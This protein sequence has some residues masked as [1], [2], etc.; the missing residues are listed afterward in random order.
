MSCGVGHRC[1]SDP[2]LLWLWCRL[3]AVAPIQPLAWELPHGTGAALK[4]KNQM[5]TLDSFLSLP[6]LS[7]P[8]SFP[9]CSLPFLFLS[10]LNPIPVL[11]FPFPSSY[12]VM[13]RCAEAPPLERE[14]EK[15]GEVLWRQA[16]SGGAPVPKD[17]G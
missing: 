12:R 2:E 13:K 8:V 3:A 17:A 9:S 6:L 5:R 1:G 10:L 7:L 16:F 11:A 15:G 4:K 14:G